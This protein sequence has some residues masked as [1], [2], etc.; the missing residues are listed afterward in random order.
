ML[1]EKFVHETK[2]WWTEYL[3]KINQAQKD[4]NLLNDSMTVLYPTILVATKFEKHYMAELIGASLGF[5][6]LSVKIHKE[7]SIY[8]YL[9]QF[10]DKNSSSVIHLDAALTNLRFLTISTPAQIDSLKN[11]FPQID[12][13]ES[14]LRPIYEPDC[15]LSF[16]DNFI[17]TGI[18]NSTLIN[19]RK[20]LFRTK[21]I[22]SMYIFAKRTTKSQ[23]IGLYNNTIK[24]NEVKGIHTVSNGNIVKTVV[25]Q[26]QNMYLQPGLRETTIGD[27]I[28][29]HPEI[30]KLAFNARRFEYEPS[31]EWHEHDGTCQDKYINPDLMIENESGQWDIYDLKTA[32]LDRAR[33]TKDERK[34][35]RFIDYVDEGIAQLAN[36]REYFKY[37]KNQDHAREKFKM[38]VSEPKLVLVVGSWDNFDSDEVNQASRQLDKSIDFI[39]YDTF[40]QLILNGANRLLETPSAP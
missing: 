14:I 15:A 10:D 6:G 40:S 12:L 37:K 9:N 33:I 34:R 17:S 27:F 32:L 25:S 24:D 11:R 4:G 5:T 18:E 23:V 2:S 28:K 16:G 3:T 13:N 19:Q 20:N 26:F 30:I 7:K 39:D 1:F 21:N 38:H 31:L 36:Y 22:L 8:R 35:R 29:T